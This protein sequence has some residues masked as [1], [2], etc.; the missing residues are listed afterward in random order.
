MRPNGVI[1]G[2]VLVCLLSGC[3]SSSGAGAGDDHG[4]ADAG[5]DSSPVVSAE[6]GAPCDG[7]ALLDPAE[8]TR[9]A[10]WLSDTSS[11]LEGYAYTNIDTYFP[12]GP[13]RTTLVDSIV[14][15]CAA[16]APRLPDWQEYCEAI[17]TSEIVSESSY[18]PGAPTPGPPSTTSVNYDSYATQNGHDDPTVGLLQVRFSSTVHDYNYYGPIAT[19]E[20]IGCSWP[21][22]FASQSESGSFWTSEGGTVT[23]LTFMENPACNIPLAVWYVFMNAT[24]NGGASAVYASDYCGGKGIAGNVVDGL[25]S[26]LEGPGFP[27]PA[28]P[29]NSYPAGIKTRFV[30]LLGG[31]LPTPDPFGVM[32][33]PEL[34][35]YCN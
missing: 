18:Q 9:V 29:T 10:G 6:A 21:T 16:F 3:S 5:S 15:A 25:L 19:I 12:V 35:L 8:V 28:D 34:C 13:Q 30:A 32:L 20:A 33:S 31:T 4:G 14:G 1:T 24:G 17:V 22:A 26:Y 23:Y 27:R 2:S 11:G 7:G